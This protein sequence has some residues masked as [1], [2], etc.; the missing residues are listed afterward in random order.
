[1]YIAKPKTATHEQLLSHEADHASATALQPRDWSF[2]SHC[3][4][5]NNKKPSFLKHGLSQAYK[6]GNNDT[7]NELHPIAP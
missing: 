2:Q 6:F 3:L 7:I 4:W 1:M 5:R